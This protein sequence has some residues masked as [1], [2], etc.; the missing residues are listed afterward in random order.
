MKKKIKLLIIG[1]TGFIGYHLANRCIKKNWSIVS[2]STKEPTKKK[3]LKKA[4][5]LICDITKKNSLK[6][7]LNESFDFVINLGGHVDHKNYKKTYRSHYLGLKNLVEI[8][9]QKK[10]KLFIQVGSG[11]EYGK[12]SSP[13]VEGK[14]KAPKTIYN[15]S[16]YLA[17]KFLISFSKKKKFPFTILRFYQVYGPKQD[18]N[19]L[20][21]IVIFNC[22]NNQKFDCSNGKQFRNFLYIDD[23]IESIM[24]CFDHW[25]KAKNQVFN[26]GSEKNYQVK[27]LINVIKKRIGQGSPQFGKIKLR[28]DEKLNFYPSINKVKKILNW[29]PRIS[30]KEGLNL[31][32]ND[33]AKNKKNNF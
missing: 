1:G 31:T 33:F 17:S 29:K 4:K 20:I 26:I 3:R 5:Y 28:F 23:A 7:K 8:F 15:K 18:T 2:I 30:L 22:L 32:I 14:E 16:K 21:P 25:K 6:K 19:R 10:I 27:G 9:H 13:H 24:K 11:G 12:I